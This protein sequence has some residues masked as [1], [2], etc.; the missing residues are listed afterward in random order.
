MPHIMFVI[1]GLE[2]GGAERQLVQL[3]ITL[4]ERDW[5]VS[6]LAYRQFSPTSVVHQLAGSKVAV[7]SLH[8]SNGIRGLIGLFKVSRS[9]R[10]SAPDVL[11]GFM[12]HGMLT[13]RLLGRFSQVTANLSSVRNGRE[14][15][16]R[17]WL[18]R[19]TDSMT[20]AVV[21]QSAELASGLTTG[22]I[23][24][25]DHTRVIPNGIDV[26]VFGPRT[27]VSQTRELIGVRPGE[28]LWLAAGRLTPE[29]DFNNL[30]RAGE[31]LTAREL[32]IR[33]VIA[34]EGPERE[35]IT[36]EIQHLGLSDRVELLG[37]RD[38]MPDLYQASDAL[39]L[40]SAT[41]GMPNV[42]LEAM[43][44]RKPVVATAV[45][46]VREVVSDGETGL[47]VPPEDHQALADAM[48]RMMALQPGARRSMGEAGYR[49]VREEFSLER[50]VDQWEDLFKRLLREKGVMPGGQGH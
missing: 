31:A 5:D 16:L 22:R 45:G 38:D 6:I 7:Q 27:D 10:H 19:I 3:A 4:A 40:S 36:R 25:L 49:R 23:A 8:S 13:A 14:G 11:V 50:V 42:L 33:L 2:R 24:N 21:S 28:F 15:R 18:L 17:R 47:V 32:P 37:L 1:S 43:A 34:G 9:I 20:D 12:F 46:A 30:L 29:K 41:E 44:C 26:T 39:V 35:T 48:H